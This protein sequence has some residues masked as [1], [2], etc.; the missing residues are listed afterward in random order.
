MKRSLFYGV[1]VGLILVVWGCVD[2]VEFLVDDIVIS[3][4]GSMGGIGV[5]VSCS[6]LVQCINICVDEVC[7]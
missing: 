2:F 4:G 1:F 5:G 6:D 3:G 7:V